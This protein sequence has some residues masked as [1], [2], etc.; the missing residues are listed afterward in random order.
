MERRPIACLEVRR[1]ATFHDARSLSTL[2]AGLIGCCVSLA[3]G[4]AS[5]SVL[6]STLPERFEDSGTRAGTVSHQNFFCS[7]TVG[8]AFGSKLCGE[9][10]VARPCETGPCE[11]DLWSKW[12]W[13]VTLEACRQ[14]FVDVFAEGLWPHGNPN[15]RA[16]VYVNGPEGSQVQTPPVSPTQRTET[17]ENAFSF[18]FQPTRARKSRESQ[19]CVRRRP[20]T[21]T[22]SWTLSSSRPL[23]LA[24]SE[25]TRREKTRAR[26]CN[27][28]LSLCRLSGWMR[29]FW[30]LRT[31][32]DWGYRAGTC[33]RRYTGCNVALAL[34]QHNAEAKHTAIEVL[35]MCMV[36]SVMRCKRQRER[37]NRESQERGETSVGWTERRKRRAEGDEERW[38]ESACS[39]S[40]LF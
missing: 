5:C 25:A 35:R 9:T 29:G 19:W 27:L 12:F 1:P 28:L 36:R 30:R 37:G 22:T 14:V 7:N 40:L 20:R 13:Q 32:K 4:V 15:N 39:A 17:L 10:A 34:R 8:S 2:A 6:L 21:R 16:M 11:M 23:P 24:C 26:C 3:K 31:L 33:G 18:S 38:R